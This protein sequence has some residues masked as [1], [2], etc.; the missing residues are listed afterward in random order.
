MANTRFE[1]C[2]GREGV[3]RQSGHYALVAAWEGEVSGL[4]YIYKVGMSILLE[5]SGAEVGVVAEQRTDLTLDLFTC[6]SSSVS[7]PAAEI[8]VCAC[9]SRHCGEELVTEVLPEV[10]SWERIRK[11]TK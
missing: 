1:Q 6:P 10:T 2:W 7:G 3:S 8:L 5:R 4:E 11:V 9:L